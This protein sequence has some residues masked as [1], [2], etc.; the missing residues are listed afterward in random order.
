MKSI[1]I[2]ILGLVVLA[3]ACE[4]C[5]CSPRHRAEKEPRIVF[6]ADFAPFK[7]ER[8]R[9]VQDDRDRSEREQRERRRQRK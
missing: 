7:K 1:V 4:A 9:P 3:G 6:R 8:R 5:R 2:V